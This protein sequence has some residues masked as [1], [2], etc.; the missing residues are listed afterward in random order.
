MADVTG[1]LPADR[2][3]SDGADGLGM[4]TRQ[5]AG[6][7]VVAPSEE[8]DVTDAARIGSLLTTAAIRVPWLIVDLTG[9]VEEA[10]GV[11]SPQ[12][13]AR[14]VPGQMRVLSWPGC[15]LSGQD[16]SRKKAALAPTSS[17]P[18]LTRGRMTPDRP[19]RHPPGPARLHGTR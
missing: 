6:Q 18:Q 2:S 14:P 16:A 3:G 1:P 10:A 11:A 19:G 15:R 5:C 12:R 4:A 8:L 13:A 17:P 9:S 7:V